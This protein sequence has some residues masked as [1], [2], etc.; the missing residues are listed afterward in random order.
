MKNKTETRSVGRPSVNLIFPRG[1]F[2]VNQLAALNP[3]VCTL[4]VRK[5]IDAGVDD[6][7]LTLLKETVKTGVVG[8]PAFRYI[9]TAVHKGLKAARKSREAGIDTTID[10]PVNT[11][12]I[13]PTLTTG[14]ETY[15][16]VPPVETIPS[17][18][19]ADPAVVDA[20]AA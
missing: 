15:E 10:V 1:A 12:L 4:T 3:N 16:S 14:I 7:F 9:R 18:E 11:T 20:V 19:T 8:K 17:T 5:K 2:T 6:K 13:D